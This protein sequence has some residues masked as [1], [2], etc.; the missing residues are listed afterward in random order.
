MTSVF[1]WQNSIRLID[2]ALLHSIF[3]G[4]N[5]CYSLYIKQIFNLHYI[6]YIIIQTNFCLQQSYENSWTSLL[7]KWE[8][9]YN[10]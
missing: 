5:A 7:H 8:F 3:K 2:F 10:M 1:S 6:Y 4:Q 9:A